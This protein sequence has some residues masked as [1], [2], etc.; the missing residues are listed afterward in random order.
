MIATLFP[1]GVPTL[2]CPLLTHYTSVGE[3]DTARMSAHI[4]HM[5]RWVPAFLAPGSTGDGWEMPPEESDALIDFLIEEAAAQDFSLMVGILRTQRGSVIPAIT[6]ILQRHTA[7]NADVSALAKKHICGFTV[8][9]PK[10]KELSRENIHGELSAIAQT[11]VPLAIYQ[12]PQITENEM[13]P[14][15]VA[16][17][18]AEFPNVYMMKDTSGEDRVVRS[19][20]DLADLYLVRGAEGDYSS[21]IRSNGGSYDG[22]LLSTANCFAEPLSRM[23]QL[24][25]EGDIAAADALSDR[26]TRVVSAVFQDAAILEFGNPFANANKAI[27]HFFAWG[28]SAHTQ[29]PPMT[30][31]GS[32]LPEKLLA[33]ARDRLTKE[34]L[35]PAAG[36]M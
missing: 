10:G 22:F 31:S 33:T 28:P 8:T 21:W 29:P 27:D 13:S 14:E 19:G 25:A 15:T 12:L 5:R 9:P 36:Y 6:S 3:I 34:G 2:W 16:A 7:G 30:H 4:R 23:I 24:I 20:A 35:F 26:I 18:V 1:G 11:G 17:L 32:R